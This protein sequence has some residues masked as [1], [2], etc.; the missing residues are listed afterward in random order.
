M[1][2][3]WVGTLLRAA[4]HPHPPVWGSHPVALPPLPLQPSSTAN[5][6]GW[7]RWLG[8]TRIWQLEGEGKDV[9]APCAWGIQTS[10]LSRS[11]GAQQLLM[12]LKGV[13]RTPKPSAHSKRGAGR[14]RVADG[15]ICIGWV[16][17]MRTRMKNSQS[18]EGSSERAAV[19]SCLPC[20]TLTYQRVGVSLQIISNSVTNQSI[21]PST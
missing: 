7:M 17:E 12:L 5:L 6:L 3:L 13:A 21:G 18:T 16:A 10:L 9:P 8:G 19:Y 20:R 4:C 15:G 2:P 11:M 1:Q 14:A